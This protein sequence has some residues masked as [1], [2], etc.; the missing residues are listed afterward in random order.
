MNI[1]TLLAPISAE[2]PCGEY[3]EYDGEFLA[4]E[5]ILI[6]KPEQQFGDV[7]IPAEP[8]NW[9]EVEKHAT[10]LFSRS[11]DLRIIIALTQSWLNIRGLSGY[12]DGLGLL[13]QTLERYWEEVWPK[14]EFDG[15]YDFLLR[16]NTLAAIEDGSPCTI[17]AQRTVI[18]KSVSKEL[19]L[20]EV[21]SL[22]NG[23]VTEIKGYTGGRT[24]L[25]DELRQ[26]TNNPEIMAMIAIREHLT[27]LTDIIRHHL[28][29]NHI[30]ELPQFLKQL[31]TIIEFCPIHNAGIDIS[32]NAANTE[33]PG[34][35]PSIKQK[36]STEQITSPSTTITS[37]EK[38]P[39]FYWHETEA[40]NRDE[41]RILLEKAKA[42][43]L[44]YEPSHPAPMMIDR[45]QRL[46]DRD[47]MK[48]IHD[49]SPESVS[50][51]EIVFGRL[52]NPD[53]D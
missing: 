49:L 45:I 43:F 13:R 40:S 25:I 2:S 7:L 1:D 34:S 50:Q 48:I 3:L 51:L 18:L 17:K 23:T 31:D 37:P 53:V 26:Q 16:L 14:L 19:S 42:Y 4:L 30:P 29:N 27:A 9:I 12:A 28:S 5:Q 15:E 20:Q 8:P 11:K 41:A 35:V 47:F 46:I 33:L 24:R 52:N 38:M 32:E 22:L 44:K 6:E 39:S 10:Q 36:T 21:C